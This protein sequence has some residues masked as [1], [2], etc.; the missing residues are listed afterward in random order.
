MTILDLA[1]EWLKYARS[2]YITA[3]HMFDDVYPREIEISCYHAQQCAEKSL[4]AFLILREIDPPH[5]HDLV[6]LCKICTVHET[7]FSAM[8]QYCVSL[9]PYGVHVRYPNELA[10]DDAIAKL[11]I[12]NAQIIYDFCAGK[13]PPE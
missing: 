8:H 5:I 2:D 11:A 7:S 6:E 9:T 3:K 10:V 1:K 4:K 12:D 13:I